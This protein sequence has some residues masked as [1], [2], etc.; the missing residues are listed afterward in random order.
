MRLFFPTALCAA[1]AFSCSSSGQTSEPLLPPPDAG[2][3]G[4]TGTPNQD[5]AS[6]QEAAAP[7]GGW[8]SDFV[9]SWHPVS[10]TGGATCSDGSSSTFTVSP[11]AHFVFTQAD[12]TTIVL[13]AASG[14]VTSYQVAGLV[15]TLDPPGQSCVTTT[16][17]EMATA[18]WTTNQFTLGSG[19][20]PSTMTWDD[21]AFVT[22]SG[23]ANA[24]CNSSSTFDFVRD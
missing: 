24:T 10:G 8:A 21:V 7:E 19:S 9:G 3:S 13:T 4:N 22:V 1:A 2:S 14:C 12:A 15:A 11:T 16:N 23:T 20:P 17:G 5:A 18:T 6:V